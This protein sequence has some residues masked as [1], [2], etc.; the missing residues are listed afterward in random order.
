MT[1]SLGRARPAV[2]MSFVANG[3]MFG[4]WASRIPAIK[5]QA[6][7]DSIHLGFAL[8]GAPL[9]SVLT[10]TLA[11]YAAGR[12]GSHRVRTRDGSRPPG[13]RFGPAPCPP[14]TGFRDR[15]I[16]RHYCKITSRELTSDI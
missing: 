16:S 2:V 11:G 14:K 9:G 12:I 15:K 5:E 4:S 3:V 6:R 1:S 8:L 10:M 13:R 7:L